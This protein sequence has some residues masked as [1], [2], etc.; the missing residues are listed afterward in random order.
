VNLLFAGVAFIGGA[1]LLQRQPTPVKPRL[2]V[3]GALL[4]SGAVFC[5]VDRRHLRRRAVIAGVLLRPGPL[6]QQGTPSPGTWQG[7][8][9]TSHGRPRP[10]GMARWPEPAHARLS[11]EDRCP[12]ARKY[13][14]KDLMAGN[15]GRAF[16]HPV[17]APPPGS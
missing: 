7:A 8:N 3:L 1:L 5:L 6:D 16:H 13:Q 2:D 15:G 17:P 11:A 4:V 14:V 9:R 10:S 12:A